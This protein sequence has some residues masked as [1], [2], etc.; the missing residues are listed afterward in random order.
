MLIST[1]CFF[2]GKNIPRRYFFMSYRSSISLSMPY[3]KMKAANFLTLFYYKLKRNKHSKIES[4]CRNIL[5]GY[6]HLIAN[7]S[8]WLP[9]CSLL[10]RGRG[11]TRSKKQWGLKQQH[12]PRTS[13][14]V[15][16]SSSHIHVQ[17][18][19]W[20]CGSSRSFIISLVT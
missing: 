6:Y 20:S 4:A 5:M 16:Q 19:L 13:F 1:D 14:P 15:A 12:L 8:Y 18:E 10:L 17:T 2:P 11:R 9:F 7:F 3:I